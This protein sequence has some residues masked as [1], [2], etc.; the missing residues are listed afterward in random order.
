MEGAVDEVCGNGLDD[1]CDGSP[2]EDCPVASCLALHQAQPQLPSGVY[3]IDPDL[4]GP[5]APF[6]VYCDMETDG[7]GWTYGSIVKTTTD[8]ADR[9]RVPGVVFFGQPV[10]DKLANEYSVNLDGLTFHDVRIDN[11]SKP[12]AVTH[13]SAALLTWDNSTYQSPFGTPAKRIVINNDWEVRVGFYGHPACG[14]NTTNIPMCFTLT[15]NPIS[16]ICDTD[17]QPGEGWMDPTAGEMCGL[18]YCYKLWRDSE[19]TSY[20][21][22]VGIQGIAVR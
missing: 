20:T 8:T 16:Y 7:G 13:T 19:C 21:A 2:D 22:A 15:A 18:Y 9:T 10:N 3:T 14:I 1:D 4:G 17:G 12:S 6:P 11:F 5:I